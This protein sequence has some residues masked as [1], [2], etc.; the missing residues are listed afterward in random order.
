MNP[1][2]QFNNDISVYELKDILSKYYGDFVAETS[3]GFL[4]KRFGGTKNTKSGILFHSKIFHN[5]SENA[6][7]PFGSYNPYALV[8]YYL[9]NNTDNKKLNKAILSKFNTFKSTYKLSKK[10]DV[11]K[12]AIITP[13]I[14]ANSTG[15]RIYR[16]SYNKN[17]INKANNNI[18][19]KHNTHYVNVKVALQNFKKIVKYGYSFSAYMKSDNCKHVAE[20]T[21]LVDVIV[22]DIDNKTN[23][24]SIQD[25]LKLKLDNFLFLYTSPSH[26]KEFHKYRVIFDIHNGCVKDNESYKILYKEY[27]EKL[28]NADKST[29]NINRI[30]FSNTNAIIIDKYDKM[31]YKL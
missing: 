29:N 13:N 2:E 8:L 19:A 3:A 5:F 28:P 31:E 11:E 16:I 9:F 7:I 14:L 24:M 21:Q 1:F 18:L 23:Y 20:N 27:L 12:K 6:S 25:F 4:F 15:E 22:L 10:N 26:K 17:I 30:W